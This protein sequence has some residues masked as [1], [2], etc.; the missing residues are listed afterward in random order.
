MHPKNMAGSAAFPSP[1]GEGQGEGKRRRQPVDGG[2]SS[3]NCQ[4]RRVLRQSQRLPSESMKP[5]GQPPGFGA[6]QSCRF[7]WAA[8]R[9]K[10]AEG[11]R[12]SRRFAKFGVRSTIAPALG[13][14]PACRRFRMGKPTELLDARSAVLHVA[15]PTKAGASSTHSKRFA[16]YRAQLQ[17]AHANWVAISPKT[18][19]V[20]Q[21]QIQHPASGI[22]SF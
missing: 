7:R 17:T 20:F 10:T 14:R 4:A 12:T 2:R 9:S 11:G 6:R 15:Q 16:T 5:L 3:Q 18:T 13:V 19:N 21:S 22:R 8:L 1:G